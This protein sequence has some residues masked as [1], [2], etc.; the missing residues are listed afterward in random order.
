[1]DYERIEKPSALGG[2]FS[3]GKLRAMLLGVEKRRQ[4]EEEELEARFSLRSDLGELDGR[5]T[6][7]TENCKDVEI[8][9][10]GSRAPPPGEDL[11]DSESVLL[12]FEF[13]RAERSQHHRST[14]MPPF[15][16]PAPSKWDDAQKWIASPTSSKHGKGGIPQLKKTG[17]MGYGGRQYAAASKVILEVPEEAA[18]KK[19]DPNQGR[20]DTSRKKGASGVQEPY[21]LVDWGS[22]APPMAEESV[23]DHEISLSQHDTSPSTV[24]KTTMIMPPTTVKS[25]SMRDMGTEMTPIASQEPSRN[26]TPMRATTPTRSPIS[27]RPSTPPKTAPPT[28]LMSADSI[29]DK[30]LSEKELRIRTKREIM[31]L[32]TQLGKM[33]ITAWASKDDE[34]THA[35][36]SSKMDMAGQQPNSVI[37]ARAA[38]WEEAEKAKYL[39]RFKREEIKIQAWENHQK[40]K[41]E[42]E[43]RKV[44]VEVERM[45]ARAHDKVMSKQASAKHKAEDKRAAAEARRNQHAA[46]TAQQAE[47]IRRTGRNPSSSCWGCCS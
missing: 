5:R 2:G 44:E 28:T 42:A 15:S 33:N 39:A 32:G 30:E 41:T 19:M 38:A 35:S 20:K 29:G 12:G 1:M 46:R 23:P 27:S 26:G 13:Q 34:E 6:S 11:P 22:I 18:T 25:V 3:P 43:M 7:I 36:T 9:S 17:F 10:L 31:A 24:S 21:P 4:D 16:K 8:V 37:E 45:R 40:A 47:N 14:L